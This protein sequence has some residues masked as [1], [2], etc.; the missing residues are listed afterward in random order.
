[1]TKLGAAIVIGV[2]ALLSFLLKDSCHSFFRYGGD[3]GQGPGRRLQGRQAQ[4]RRPD[5]V[6]HRVHP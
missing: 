3:P 6:Q 1:M 4:P 2:I 5:R